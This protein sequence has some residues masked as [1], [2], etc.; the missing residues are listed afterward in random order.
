[1]RVV[2][3]AGVRAVSRVRRPLH[4]EAPAQDGRVLQAS[5]Q[6]VSEVLRRGSFG[7]FAKNNILYVLWYQVW[8]NTRVYLSGNGYQYIVIVLD[9]LSSPTKLVRAV[10]E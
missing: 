1:M 2:K 6:E 9:R 4:L 7:G 3:G 5:R 10:L 8:C